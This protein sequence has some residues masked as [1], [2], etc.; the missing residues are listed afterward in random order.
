MAITAPARPMPAVLR[1]AMVALAALALSWTALVNGQ[2][3]F[4]PDT[5]GYIRGPDVAV[6]K[7]LGPRFASPWASLDPGARVAADVARANGQAPP[8]HVDGHG[9]DDKAV[10]GGRS[11]YYGVLAD[12][13]A[14]TGG[15]WLTVLVQALAVA[16]L[17]EIVLR[18]LGLA[19]WRA[20]AVVVAVLALASPAALFVGFLMPDIWVGVAVGALAALF[21]LA[22]RLRRLDV[23]ALAL[24]IVFAAL[25][26]S[27]APLV[28]AA[29]ML[30]AA[31]LWVLNRRAWRPALGLVVGLTALVAA[32]AG[33]FA[34]TAMVRHATGAPPLNPPFI[35]ARLVADG[36]GT[37]YAKTR[38]AGQGFEVCRFADRFPIDVDHFL[39]GETAQDGVFLTVAPAERRALGAEQAR[40]ALAVVRAYPLQQVQAS[41]Q[42]AWA[43]VWTTELSDFNYKPSLQAGFAQ[44]LPPDTVA[45]MAHTLAAGR[46]WPLGLMWV[47]QSATLAVLL[48]AAALANRT[49]PRTPGPAQV[50][51]AARRLVVLCL[52]GVLA[53]GVI[54]GVF[55][56]LYGRYQ[57]RTAWVLPLAALAWLMARR[58]AERSEAAL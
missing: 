58:Q 18:A 55:S 11:I 43:Q 54:C 50:V 10:M 9:F 44:T 12:L 17:V 1:C 3:F 35:T 52:A 14:R 16:W 39:W 13:G 56:T 49:A 19:S 15:L 38:C 20:Y 26:H 22:G 4:H 36:T 25:S 32:A 57:A 51:A 42:N 45:T 33:G 47:I 28:I 40:F 34:F 29:M 41:L 6:M 23:A 27:T 8:A 24:M 46:S 30:A 21:S 31:G 5:L 37:A 53:N 2:P 48:G 7:L